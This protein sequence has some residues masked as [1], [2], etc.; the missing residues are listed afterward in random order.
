[1]AFL[2]LDTGIL[3]STLW[4]D[5]ECREVF[6]TALLMAEPYEVTEPIPQLEVRTMTET[7]FFVP[8]GWYGLVHAAGVGIVRRA[9]VDEAPGMEAL[10]RLGNPDLES[11]SQEFDGRRLGRVNGGYVALN[12]MKFRD[13]DHTD[14]KSVV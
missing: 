12:F 14:R 13:R 3:N 10:E 1:M 4:V 11:R 8:V 2:K 6:I 9:L 7:G 5:R